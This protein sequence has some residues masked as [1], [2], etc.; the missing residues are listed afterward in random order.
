M[1]GPGQS[2]F[3]EGRE[4]GS[5]QGREEVRA[6]RREEGIKARIKDHLEENIPKER[7]IIKLQKYFGITLEKAEQFYKKYATDA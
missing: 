2:I 6:Q 3:E 4:E 1:K 5:A 7:S